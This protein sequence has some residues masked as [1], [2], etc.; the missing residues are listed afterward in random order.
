MHREVKQSE[1]T[2]VNNIKSSNTND[3]DNTVAPEKTVVFPSNSR[4]LSSTSKFLI[5]ILN[6]HCLKREPVSNAIDFT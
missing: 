5:K 2:M 4:V 1:E 3:V 6:E